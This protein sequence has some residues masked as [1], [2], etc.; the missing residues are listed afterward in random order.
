MRVLEPSN[1]LAGRS[2]PGMRVMEPYRSH[3]TFVGMEPN[4]ERP[5]GLTSAVGAVRQ[6]RVPSGPQVSYLDP[7]GGPTR[8]G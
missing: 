1:S 5:R 2:R 4:P 6:H 3:A 7:Y 8:P